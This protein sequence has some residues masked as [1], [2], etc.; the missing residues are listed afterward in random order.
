MKHTSQTSLKVNKVKALLVSGNIKEAVA[1]AKAKRITA[2][3]FGKIAKK[4]KVKL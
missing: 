2:E 4:C 1:Y 3:E